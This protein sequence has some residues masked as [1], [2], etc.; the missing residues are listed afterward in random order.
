MK[1]KLALYHGL[2]AT[3][4]SEKAV[5]QSSETADSPTE[6]NNTN[7]QNQ[8]VSTSEKNTGLRGSVREELETEELSEED[9]QTLMT[10]GGGLLLAVGFGILAYRRRRDVFEKIQFGL[11]NF[12]KLLR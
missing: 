12:I 4:D 2:M 7:T 10:A 1:K 8:L 5:D 9:L 6:G 11:R 3:I